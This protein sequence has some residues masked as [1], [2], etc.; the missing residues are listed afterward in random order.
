M[1][2]H[3]DRAALLQRLEELRDYVQPG[4]DVA[5]LSDKELADLVQ[6]AEESQ[7]ETSLRRTLEEYPPYPQSAG[8]STINPGGRLLHR[9]W[10]HLQDPGT[11]RSL[12]VGTTVVLVALMVIATLTGV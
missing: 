8:F 7:A 3:L 5:E 4:T 9:L 2:N 11:L 1:E 10:K 6:A 12:L